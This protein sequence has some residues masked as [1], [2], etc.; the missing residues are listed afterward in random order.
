MV[1]ANTRHSSYTPQ[2]IHKHVKR[3]NT[4]FLSTL[5]ILL[6]FEKTKDKT[7]KKE[8]KIYWNL[9]SNISGVYYAL[10]NYDKAIDYAKL[11]ETVDYNK[12]WCFNLEIAEKR[13]EVVAKNKS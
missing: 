5:T 12:K 4:K 9:L 13:K 1:R 7:D 6:L 2:F 10:G 11:R 8:K 3:T